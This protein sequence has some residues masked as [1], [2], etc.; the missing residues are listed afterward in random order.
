MLDSNLFDNIVNRKL[1]IHACFFLWYVEK[2][3]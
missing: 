3:L 1:K 2:F